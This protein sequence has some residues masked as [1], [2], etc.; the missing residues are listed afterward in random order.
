[1][2]VRKRYMAVIAGV[3]LPAAGLAA[4]QTGGVTP[5]KAFNP[6][7]ANK[8]QQRILSQFS[9][10]ATGFRAASVRGTGSPAF[11]NLTPTKAGGPQ[12]GLSLGSNVK[13]NQGCLNISA[14]DLQGRGQAQNETTIAV[15]P[16]NS[17][18]LLA[19][20]NDYTLGDGLAGG[21]SYSSNGGK[22]WQD[23]Q[24]PLEFTRGSDFPGDPTSRMYWQGG[25]DPSVAWD[26]RGDAFFAGLHF[27]RGSGTS[28]NPDYS[29]GVYVYRSVGNGGASWS[30]PGT[31]VATSFQPTTPA[32]GVPLL[33]KP[34]M[35]IDNHTGSPYRDR[36]YVTYTNFAADGTAYIYGAWSSDYGRSFSAPVLVSKTSRL[37]PQNY[38]SIGVATENGN[39]CDENQYSDP[40]TGSDGKLYVVYSNFNTADALNT[41]PG[42]DNRYQVLLSRSTD[43][44]QTFSA[45][46][47]VGQYY[48]LPDCGTYQAG[49]DE[50]RS[51]VPEQGSQQDSVFRATNY[52][53]GAVDP[54][55]SS[56]IAVTYGSYISKDST[57]P[58]CTPNGT[59]PDFFIPLYSGVKTGGCANKI[60]VSVS[61]DHGT[62]FDGT[63][64]DPRTQNVVPQAPAQVHTDQWF[65]W[66][67]FDNAGHVVAS[68]Y[69]RSY[70]TDITTGKMDITL[71]SQSG[72]TSTFN[73]TRVTSSSMPLPTQFGDAQGNGLFFG[74]YSGLA[75]SSTADPLWS[76]TRDPDLFDCGTDP[77]SLCIGIESGNGQMA[78][79]Q[80]IFTRS[81]PT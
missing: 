81:L 5:V 80:D 66:S 67:A 17:Q 12:C 54:T 50:G 11:P 35:T 7:T 64:T 25:G 8:I 30:F 9:D 79:D 78:N 37:C 38:T 42:S 61:I 62:S 63:G 20:S 41:A 60:M 2:P 59:D 45:P 72:A 48:D 43:G 3:I 58:G 76:D 26:S 14:P 69:D 57:A 56:H 52:P 1:M 75:A 32:S 40:F 6:N 13:V 44:G 33:D 19:A 55:N 29:S 51:C 34:Y 47:Q 68:Y 53:S 18:Q 71:S 22:T 15:N 77:P 23:S 74:D 70:G 24:V 4:F 46:I 31:P 21:T 27:N 65:Q 28:D 36:V 10:N 49:Q 39:N 16:R 73:Q